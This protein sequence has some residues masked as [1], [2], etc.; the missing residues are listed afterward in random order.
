MTVGKTGLVFG[1]VLSGCH[2]FWSMMVALGW[3]QRVIDCIFWMHFIKPVLVIKPFKVARAAIL[4]AVTA[5]IGFVIGSAFAW[6]WN[7][8][9]KR[10]RSA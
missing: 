2:L 6:I 5:S 8:M 3:A 9:C 7:A 4:I 10:E 1:A